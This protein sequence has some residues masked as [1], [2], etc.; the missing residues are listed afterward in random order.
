MPLY[1]VV[2]KRLTHTADL[3]VAEEGAPRWSPNKPVPDGPGSQR[4]GWSPEGFPY[5]I[6]L[7]ILWLSQA[8]PV[9]DWTQR[10]V[11]VFHKGS[12]VILPLNQKHDHE[13]EVVEV[14]MCTTKQMAE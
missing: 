6:I 11:R 14:N 1:Q 5:K 2:S 10:H 8:N 12:D 9:I 3:C 13:T 7:G 4:R